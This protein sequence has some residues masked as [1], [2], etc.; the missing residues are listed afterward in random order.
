MKTKL[1]NLAMI[2]LVSFLFVG[3]GAAADPDTMTL[4]V[5]VSATLSVSISGDPYNFETVAPNS[6]TLS[7]RAITVTND[8]TNAIEDYLLSCTPPAAGPLLLMMFAD[9]MNLFCR[10]FSI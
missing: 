9:Q 6:S 1:L 4:S 8:S 3:Y 5:T 2:T 10:R 7:T